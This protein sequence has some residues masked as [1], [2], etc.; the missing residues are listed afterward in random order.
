MKDTAYTSEA[1]APHT[2]TTY[3]N[4]PARLQ[5]FHMLSHTDGTGGDTQLV[6]GF[7]AAT[8]LEDEDKKAWR[9]LTQLRLGSH[10]SGNPGIS[11]QNDC[12]APTISLIGDKTS[13]TIR[14]IRWNNDDRNAFGGN[15]D[16]ISKW[17]TSA[18]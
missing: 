12:L 10:A 5:M 6:D 1:L 11:V 17:Y 9:T 4:E 7:Q 15:F 16:A 3:F 2:D 8:Q 13:E 14:Q 18:R